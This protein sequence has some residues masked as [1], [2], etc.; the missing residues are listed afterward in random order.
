[1]AID[2][3]IVAISNIGELSL[4]KDIFSAL[5]SNK[6]SPSALNTNQSSLK[7]TKNRGFPISIGIDLFFKPF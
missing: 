1:M 6:H 2:R 4:G 5:E 7:E 3:F